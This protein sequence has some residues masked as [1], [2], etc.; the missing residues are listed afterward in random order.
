[1]SY[2]RSAQ[3]DLKRIFFIDPPKM[4]T[5]KTKTTRRP[6]R[7]QNLTSA[8]CEPF[9]SRQ[10]LSASAP[11]AHTYL[12]ASSFAASSVVQGYTPA[13]IRHAYGFDQLTGDGSGQTIAIVDAFR[14]PNLAAD[15]HAFDV[16]MGIA[17]P[18]SLKNISQTGGSAASVKVDSGWAGEISLDVEWAHAIAPKANILLV[19]ANSDSLADLMSAVDVAR[20]AAGVSVV[21]MS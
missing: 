21:S 8:P 6:L 3:R 9:E 17:D 14:D 4:Q 11:V 13:Q 10:L 18:P 2:P 19:S 15:L 5:L 7:S 16:A 12:T 1:M 20:R